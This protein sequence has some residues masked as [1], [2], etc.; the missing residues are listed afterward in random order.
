[1]PQRK[2]EG[3]AVPALSLNCS[4]SRARSGFRPRQRESQDH[5][6]SR[7]P[8]LLPK[9]Q[10]PHLRGGEGFVPWTRAVGTGGTVGRYSY[11]FPLPTAPL[12]AAA[13]SLLSAFCCDPSAN[14]HAPRS[15]T[16]SRLFSL[17]LNFAPPLTCCC[18]SSLHHC[19]CGMPSLIRLPYGR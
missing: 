6:L 19:W 15:P 7:R 13:R 9:A 2:G 8:W 4:R 11:C 10:S 18:F 1:M 17:L 12:P 5:F 14:I 16:G 3:A